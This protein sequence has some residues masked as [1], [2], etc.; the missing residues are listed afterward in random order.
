MYL[1]SHFCDHMLEINQG[2]PAYNV[3]I[4]QIRNIVVKT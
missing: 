2:A 1:N 3:L 4:M